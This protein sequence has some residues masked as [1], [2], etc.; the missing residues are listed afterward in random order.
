LAASI[1][2]E[3][4]NP[5]ESVT[6]LLY[7]AR[8]SSDITEVR[9]YL[10]T[11][12]QELRRV[13]LI[14]N[15]TL[16]FHRQ[17]SVPMELIPSELIEAVLSMYHGRLTNSHIAVETDY[18]PALVI[19]CFEGE[20]RQVLSNLVGNAIDAMHPE[21]G[22]LMLRTRPAVN[23]R[24]GTA[25]VAITVADSGSGMAELVSRR[26]F[27]AFFTTKGIGGTGL[28]LW[29]AQ[30]IVERHHGTLRVRSRRAGANSGTVFRLFLPSDAVM[31]AATV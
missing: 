10:D 16:R 24:D 5:L 12:E 9:A 17:A 19:R 29:V 23:W 25:G 20:I 1:A 8:A 18:A 30:Q 26:I 4:N 7:L 13:A 31:R 11:A 14:S 28:G 21:G 2:H 27:K 15:Q 3:I 22:R 6:N